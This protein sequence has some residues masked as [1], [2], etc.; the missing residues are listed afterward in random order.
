M[1][2]SDAALGEVAEASGFTNADHFYK[3]FARIEGM[4]PTEYRQ[5]RQ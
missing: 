4:S 3:V 2:E 5:A 1:V